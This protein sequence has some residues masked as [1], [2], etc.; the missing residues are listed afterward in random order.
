MPT[1]MISLVG[2]RTGDAEV[3]RILRRETYAGKAGYIYDCHCHRCGSDFEAHQSQ[4]HLGRVPRHC[5]AL[6]AQAH[7]VV[8]YE[9]RPVVAGLTAAPTQAGAVHYLLLYDCTLC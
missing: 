6:A 9:F 1:H 3:R 2:R 7:Q 8:V 5:R 4:I